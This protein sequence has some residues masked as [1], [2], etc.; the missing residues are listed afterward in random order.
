MTQPDPTALAALVD[1]ATTALARRDGLVVLGLSGAQGSGKSTLAAALHRHMAAAGI[2]TASLSLDDLYRTRAERQRMAA[3][4]HPLFITRG[5]PGTHDVTMGLATITSLARGAPA[6]MPRFDKARDDRRAVGDDDRAPAHTRLLV[7]EGWCLGAVPQSAAELAPPINALEAQED[8]GA[9]WRGRV[10][11]A[12]AGD[13]ATLW[14]RSDTMAMLRAPDFATVAQWR[15]Q[16]EAALRQSDPH[17]P[18]VMDTAQVARFVAHYERI[19]RGLLADLPARA[20]CVIDLDTDR[21]VTAITH[22]DKAGG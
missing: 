7:F 18:G 11:A 4:M 22:R 17:A 21:R 15:E 8:R 14:A 12:L 2:A 5:V 1:L 20:D 3:G 6:L 9:K 19:T 16:Q 10:N 13:Y